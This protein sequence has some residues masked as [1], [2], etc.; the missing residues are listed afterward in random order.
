MLSFKQLADTNPSGRKLPS[1]W[2]QVM[3]ACLSFAVSLNR[4]VAKQT[5]IK[6]REQ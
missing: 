2:E 3:A 1:S 5:N 4:K 6:E